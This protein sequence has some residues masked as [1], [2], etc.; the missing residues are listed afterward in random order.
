MAED[1]TDVAAELHARG[2]ERLDAGD[3]A[4]ADELAAR[5]AELFASVDPGHPDVANA[6]LL[7]A[8]IAHVRSDFAAELGLAERATAILDAALREYPDEDIVVTL[9]AHAV[10]QL[11]N[12]M[13]ALGRYDDAERALVACLAT[14]EARLGADAAEVGQLCNLLGIGHK[15]QARYDEAAARYARAAAIIAMHQGNDSIEMASLEHNLGGLAHAR[16]EPAIGEPHARRAVEL[17]EAA[18][19][20]DH[21]AVAADLAAWAALLDDLGRTDEAEAALRRALGIFERTYGER[22]FEVGYTLGSLGALYAG[23]ER[24]SDA[25][26]VLARAREILVEVLGA[27]NVEVAR[28]EQYL[29]VMEHGRGNASTALAHAERALAICERAFPSEHPRLIDARHT[30]DTIAGDAAR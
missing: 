17:R 4:A 15:Y 29:A 23:V 10:G 7:R 21:P 3:V 8:Q 16:G 27:D 28:V 2:E 18:L 22:H 25:S 14:T 5:A 24:W 9:H 20:D 6:L 19:G 1:P 30:R 12:A 26:T 13:H 11:A